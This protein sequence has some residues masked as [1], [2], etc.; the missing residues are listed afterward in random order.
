MF[1]LPRL[2]NE[3]LGPYYFDYDLWKWSCNVWYRIFQQCLMLFQTFTLELRR[4]SRP[5][6]NGLSQCGHGVGLA[7]PCS[8]HCRPT[9]RSPCGLRWPWRVWA[10]RSQ[11]SQHKK[12][13]GE[14]DQ[15]LSISVLMPEHR[16]YT[17]WTW[18]RLAWAS[19]CFWSCLDNSDGRWGLTCAR[20]S[21]VPSC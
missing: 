10:N 15:F 3:V 18:S 5:I 16:P 19:V 20:L 8:S 21:Q 13:L 6:N 1:L 14:T 11:A 17:S 9:A 2:R 7:Q 4:G 12:S